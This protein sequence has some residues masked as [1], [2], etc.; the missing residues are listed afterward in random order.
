[1]KAKIVSLS[2]LA[3]MVTA[4]YWTQAQH[5][6]PKPSHKTDVAMECIALTLIQ[7][8]TPT[9]GGLRVQSWRWCMQR[10]SQ[11]PKVAIK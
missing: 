2:I 8:K 4:L 9:K 10:G 3:T 11:I 1:M 7:I 6:N 5:F